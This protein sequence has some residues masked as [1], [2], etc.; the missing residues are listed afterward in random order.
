MEIITTIIM[1][2]TMM[3]TM[4][5]LIQMIRVWSTVCISMLDMEKLILIKMKE[6]KSECIRLP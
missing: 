6:R 2:T 3:T 1:M 4:V 5:N